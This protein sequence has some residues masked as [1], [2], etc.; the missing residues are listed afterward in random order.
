MITKED[1]IKSLAS[2]LL[3]DAGYLDLNF[4]IDLADTI[5]NTKFNI[6]GEE[7]FLFGIENEGDVF[8]NAIESIKDNC[9]DEFKIDVN[10]L[11]YEILNSVVNRINELYNLE[12][13]EGTDFHIFINCID[14]HLSL[15]E[16]YTNKDL[17]TEELQ[18]IKN[19]FEVFN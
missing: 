10:G 11:I 13:E 8:N 9:G 6:K 16:D 15:S 12:L 3:D 1:N 2:S 4:L 5:D 7:S 19:I 14:S 18:E 17:T